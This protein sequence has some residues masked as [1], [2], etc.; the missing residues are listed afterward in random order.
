MS[1]LREAAASDRSQRL[2][3]GI[4]R[5][6]AR[7]LKLDPEVSRKLRSLEGRSLAVTLD[8]PDLSFYLRCDDRQLRAVP[9]LPDAPGAVLKATPGAF[10]A[11]AASGGTGA[12]GKVSVEGDAETARRFQQFFTDL[13]PDWEEALTSLFGDVMGFQVSQFM[14]RGLSWLKSAGR[15]LSETGSEYLREE[16]RQL[17]TRPEMELFLDAVDDLREDVDRLEARIRARRRRAD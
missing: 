3:D 16:S 15:G 13:S 11:L 2:A 9:G 10:M 8:G 5:L 1:E 17:V 4:N 6:L 12:V 14:E 7:F